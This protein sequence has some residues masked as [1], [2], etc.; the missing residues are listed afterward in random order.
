MA[1]LSLLYI[2]IAIC[3][4]LY[5]LHVISRSKLT[6]DIFLAFLAK[7]FFLT[8][9]Y[10]LFFFQTE[11]KNPDDLDYQFFKGSFQNRKLDND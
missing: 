3:Y 7:V 9:I 5:K 6:R 1:S 10:L 2:A 11:K 8:I 4:I